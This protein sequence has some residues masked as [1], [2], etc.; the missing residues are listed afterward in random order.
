VPGPCWSAAAVE[1]T[2][3]KPLPRVSLNAKVPRGPHTLHSHTLIAC[4]PSSFPW[5]CLAPRRSVSAC[6]RGWF[7]TSLRSFVGGTIAGLAL[8]TLN[9]PLMAVA[10]F[11]SWDFGTLRRW[12]ILN[13]TY[14]FVILPRHETE[15]EIC[16]ACD[17]AWRL[18]QIESLSRLVP[19][20]PRYRKKLSHDIYRRRPRERKRSR[21]I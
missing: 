8:I 14:Q 6:S 18:R 20:L 11:L 17:I 10:Y 15:P 3:R 19:W 2:T 21:S 1:A 13:L 9:Y 7:W 16:H 4:I 5:S 12:M